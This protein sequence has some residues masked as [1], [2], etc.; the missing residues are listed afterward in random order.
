MRRVF[1]LGENQIMKRNIV[2]LI[3]MVLASSM[4]L[5]LNITSS[6]N[7][8]QAIANVSVLPSP[9]YAR[10]GQ[11][12]MVDLNVSDVANLLAY[13]ISIWY[14]NSF[15]NATAVVRPV[16]HF[17]E[18]SNPAN[19]FVVKWEIK[20]DYNATHG[21]IWLGYT[22]LAPEVGRSGSGIL[23]RVTF[24]IKTGGSSHIVLNDYP[25]INGP[26]KLAG[27]DTLPI[28]HTATDGVIIVG[29]S[30]NVGRVPDSPSY[31]DQV[32]VTV[33]V[34]GLREGDIQTVILSHSYSSTDGSG[35]TNNTMVSSGG[36]MYTANIP[37]Y[38]Y[39]TFVEYK[40]YLLDKWGFW[41]ISEVYDYV[42]IDN[43]PPGISVVTVSPSR[44]LKA[45]ITES[46]NASGVDRAYFSFK[47]AKWNWWNT[48]MDFD[49]KTGLWT[50]TLPLEPSFM[51]QTLNYVITAYDKAGNSAFV[52]SII[53]PSAWWLADI[54]ADGRID[55][56]DIAIVALHFGEAG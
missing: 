14:A 5:E 46:A 37:P 11:Q 24:L 8:Q 22:L 18:P 31:R 7:L 4:S 32:T 50:V 52:L 1:N 41:S 20:N 21:R 43:V 44:I 10:A 47:A 25:G 48:T 51:N 33:H 19:E 35:A 12:V 29:P 28:S 45:N 40:V 2:C 9:I 54:N 26:V 13:D 23:A 38:P 30:L 16:G 34:E 27:D 42:V 49:T 39:S 6:R 55:I 53:Q 3:M 15:A 17:L 36:N 56:F